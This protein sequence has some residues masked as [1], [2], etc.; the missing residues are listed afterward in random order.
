MNRILE[1][2]IKKDQEGSFEPISSLYSLRE[3]IVELQVLMSERLKK[4]KIYILLDDKDNI[5]YFSENLYKYLD[6]EKIVNLAKN[7]TVLKCMK[8]DFL[9][10]H[11]FGN[12]TEIMDNL[13][14]SVNYYILGIG[15][16]VKESVKRFEEIG[17]SRRGAAV[18]KAMVSSGIYSFLWGFM[19]FKMKELINEKKLYLNTEFFNPNSRTGSVDIDK[20]M[21]LFKSLSDDY[22][23]CLINNCLGTKTDY[24][25]DGVCGNLLNSAK[26][27]C[28]E[29]FFRKEDKKNGRR[30]R[31]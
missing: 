26:E 11:F 29:L 22:K 1:Y 20:Y 16:N 13:K 14:K 8:K 5:V 17:L 3:A 30:Q 19:K 15:N 7:E 25:I 31:A 27:I 4:Y 6:Y 2:K 18:K 9:P 12:D 21:G 24:T 28:E 23:E 10:V